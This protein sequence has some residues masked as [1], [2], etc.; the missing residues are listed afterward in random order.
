LLALV[1]VPAQATESKTAAPASG[2]PFL[3]LS[4][5]PAVHRSA[6]V[7]R[8]VGGSLGAHVS[9]V[10]LDAHALAGWWFPQ[11]FGLGLGLSTLFL[12]AGQGVKQE[13]RNPIGSRD[14]SRTVTLAENPGSRATLLGFALQGSL[15]DAGPWFYQGIVGFGVLPS[16]RAADQVRGYAGLG[17][18]GGLGYELWTTPHARAGLL[19][20]V[21]LMGLRDG[22]TAGNGNDDASLTL[23]ALSLVA[24]VSFR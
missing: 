18:V 16:F 13:V 22:Q 9:G 7:T 15:E 3:R 23:V 20:Q 19:G 6:S 10:A 24:T 8:V 5:G 21:H 14:P 17:L 1:A 2:G 11:Q 12:P 4:L